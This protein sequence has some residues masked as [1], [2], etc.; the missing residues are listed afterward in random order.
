MIN[1]LVIDDNEISNFLLKHMIRKNE[2]E[3][4]AQFYDNP[5]EALVYLKNC[6]RSN[7]NPD[8][9]LLDINMPLMTGW[10]LLDHLRQDGIDLNERIPVYM[11]S[12]SV[13]KKDMELTRNYP[14]VISF[15]SKPLSLEMLSE[16]VEK[17]L[18]SKQSES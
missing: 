4:S 9:I 16:I 2:Q 12:S 8:L 3:I 5:E 10:D 11:L 13:H 15:I 7:Q 14:E 18:S 17:T 6:I 1:L